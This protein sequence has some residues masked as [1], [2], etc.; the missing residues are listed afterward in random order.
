MSQCYS[1][2]RSSVTHPA[3]HA[4]DPTPKLAC[5]AQPPVSPFPLRFLTSGAGTNQSPLSGVALE[6]KRVGARQADYLKDPICDDF[7]YQ[8]FSNLVNA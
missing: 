8:G 7:G 4:W 2:T 6:R 3:L 5:P 1:G